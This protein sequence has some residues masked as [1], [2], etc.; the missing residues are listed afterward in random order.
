[1]LQFFPLSLIL[2]TV[3]LHGYWPCTYD[4]YPA[5]HLMLQ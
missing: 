2:Q 4:V 5:G 3:Y 1:M